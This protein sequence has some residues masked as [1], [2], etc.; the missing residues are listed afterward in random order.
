MHTWLNLRPVFSLKSE[1]LEVFA[2]IAKEEPDRFSKCLHWEVG[3]FI[4]WHFLK[5]LHSTL[6]TK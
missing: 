3:K 1:I 5:Q 2:Q 4:G 6:T